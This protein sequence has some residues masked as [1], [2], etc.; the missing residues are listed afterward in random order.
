MDYYCIL[1]H[2]EAHV[3]SRFLRNVRTYLKNY[4]ALHVLYDIS[5]SFIIMLV[6][7]RFVTLTL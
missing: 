7:R 6:R 5:I 3:S 4:M 1:G 2:D